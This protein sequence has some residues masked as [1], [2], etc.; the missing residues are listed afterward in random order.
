MTAMKRT[1]IILLMLSPLSLLAAGET[2][3]IEALEARLLKMEKTIAALEKRLDAAEKFGPAGEQ[4][5]AAAHAQ[6]QGMK[7][8][9]RYDEMRKAIQAFAPEYGHTQ[10]YQRQ[11]KKLH[12]EYLVLGKTVPADWGILKWLQGENEIKLSSKAPTLVVFW[13]LWCPHC[14]REAP[15]MEKIHQKYKAQ[16]VQVVGLT[17]LSKNT[18]EKAV[19]DFLKQQSISYPIAHE[20]GTAANHFAVSGIPAAA[21]VIDGKIVWRG[22]PGNLNDQMIEKLMKG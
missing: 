5:A 9:G 10:I 14:K 1:L 19:M 13:E 2:A 18:T 6:I 11:L 8:A 20:K 21:F 12:T 4:K 17:R 7:D 16:G 3:R 22:H 15:N